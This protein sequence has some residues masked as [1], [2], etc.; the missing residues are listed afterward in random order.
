MS[1]ESSVQPQKRSLGKYKR[2]PRVEDLVDAIEHAEVSAMVPTGT[3]ALEDFDLKYIGMLS[4]DDLMYYDDIE[5]W[6]AIGPEDVKGMSEDQKLTIL[7]GFRG[8]EWIERVKRWRKRG[9]WE[10]PPLIVITHPDE[11]GLYTQ[12]G[13]GRGR[14]VLANILGICVPVWHLEWRGDDE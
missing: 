4:A 8:R 13:D 11:G 9:T 3:W 6:Y 2:T 5:A 7:K 10:I 12:I 14:A 1:R